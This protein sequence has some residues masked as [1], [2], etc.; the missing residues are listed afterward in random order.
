MATQ[1]AYKVDRLHAEQD[2]TQSTS[3]VDQR[4]QDFLEVTNH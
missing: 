2:F 4:Q 1:T 3:A